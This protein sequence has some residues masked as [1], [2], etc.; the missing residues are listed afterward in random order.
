MSE[1]QTGNRNQLGKVQNHKELLAYKKAYEIVLLVYKLTRSFPKE[2]VYSLTSQMRRSAVSIQCNIAG[3][4]MRGSKEYM[5]FLRIALGSAA[6]LET[7]LSISRD[8][9]FSAENGFNKIYD[10]NLEVIKLLRTY[11]ARIGGTKG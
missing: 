1:S 7:Q 10:L 6:E 9:G 8:L 3:G 11:L 4:Y 5:Q 2:E